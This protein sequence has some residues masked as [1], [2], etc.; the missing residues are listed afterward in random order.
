MDEGQ[1]TISDGADH[2]PID[3]LPDNA[4][5]G[6]SRNLWRCGHALAKSE[7]FPMETSVEHHMSVFNLSDSSMSIGDPSNRGKDENG[8]SY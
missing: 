3:A 7:H 5:R 1:S 8:K 4:T 6:K 2:R